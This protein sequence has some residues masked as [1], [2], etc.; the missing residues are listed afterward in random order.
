MHADQSTQLDCASLPPSPLPTI[1]WCTPASTS[2]NA[3]ASSKELNCPAEIVLFTAGLEDYAKPIVD[4]L[5]HNYDYCFQG[6]RLYRPATV[7]CDLYPCIKDL[8]LLG[9]DLGRTVLVDDT[10]L[11]FLN[12]PDN[13]IPI[14][15]FRSVKAD[16]VSVRQ[17]VITFVG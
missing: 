13:G 8:S 16:I 7:A 3:Y 12:Q 17:N 1:F 9:R 14:Y 4:A 6:R 5:D 15:G 10:P 2:P 11:A